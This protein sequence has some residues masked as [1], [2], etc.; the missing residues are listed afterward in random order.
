MESLVQNNKLAYYREFL[1]LIPILFNEAVSV[2]LADTD[3]FIDVRLSEELPLASK[4]GQLVPAGGAVRKV[5]DSGKII[6]QE[7][8]AQ[9][10]GVA[11]QSYAFPIFE[12]KRVIGV[13]VV[14]KS[15]R[16]KQEV[17]GEASALV[18]SIEQSTKA[19]DEIANAAQFLSTTNQEIADTAKVTAEK[20]R[21]I[22][23]VTAF[24]KEISKKINMLGVN[25]AITA[26]HAE[27]E[28]KG[29]E[30]IAKEIRN[31]SGTTATSVNEIEQILSDIQAS[32]ALFSSQI[33]T[34]SASLN[35][36]SAA[37]QEVLA[38]MEEINSAAEMMRELAHSI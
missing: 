21:E 3:K 7:V 31:L 37:T 9:V 28:A 4:V 5:L 18:E 15:L 34:S 35:D 30:V 27:G 22:E 8:S 2:A 14:G 16:H 19:I 10:Y 38:S 20:T 36:Q 11:F 13:L 26:A 12:D 1:E 24:V 33:A 17:L 23:K 25:A 6:Q 29:F 32:V